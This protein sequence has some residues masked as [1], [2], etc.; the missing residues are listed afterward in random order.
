MPIEFTDGLLTAILIVVLHME[1]R[2][3]GYESEIRRLSERFRT[4]LNECR[5]KVGLK[6]LSAG[7]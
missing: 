7:E 2:I 5:E 3:G 6:P 4:A 1:Y